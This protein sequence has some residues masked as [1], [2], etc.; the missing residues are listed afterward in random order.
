M[1][2]QK[3]FESI[4]Q[5]AIDANIII[6]SETGSIK[7]ANKI[8]L[9]IFQM[10]KSELIGK[11]FDDLF[12]HDDDEFS[13]EELSN[14]ISFHDN[15]TIRKYE[16]K[17]GTILSFQVLLSIIAWNGSTALYASMRNVTERRA[18]EEKLKEAYN[19]MKI[20]SRTDPLTELANRRALKESI[21]YEENRFG[22]NKECFSIILCDIDDYKKINDTY[23]HDAGD[24]VLKELS[25]LMKE[26]LRKQDIL[27]RWGGDEFLILLP[28][29]KI[30]GAR[31][32]SE[33]LR[34]KICKKEFIF[35][36]EI[37][38]LT[39]TFGVSDYTGTYSYERCITNADKA[40]YQ[41]KELG[42]NQV[43]VYNAL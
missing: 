11:N 29:T 18:A 4:F 10:H 22:R 5:N 20:I 37:I 3:N 1:K 16:K 25:R 6:D 38:K 27:G 19:E 15:I 30:E 12:L 34:K 32:L 23:G 39:M 14:Q 41:A 35:N 9:H 24:F 43:I 21:E 42:K 36:E 31:S 8:A 33:K 2:D 40:L 26:S 28:Q 13:R 17:D 7:E